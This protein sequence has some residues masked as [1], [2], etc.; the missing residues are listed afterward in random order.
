M[1]FSIVFPSFVKSDDNIFIG[2]A[3]NLQIA[4]GNMVIFYNIDSIHP[5]GLCNHY[6][7]TFAS[8]PMVVLSK[9]PRLGT[10]AS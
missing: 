7:T 9:A 6:S 5:W 10:L 1:N 2:I 4:F 8:H 3:L